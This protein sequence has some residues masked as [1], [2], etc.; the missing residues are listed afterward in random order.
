MLLTEGEQLGI[1]IGIAALIFAIIGI[2][3]A[4]FFSWFYYKKGKNETNQ[5]FKNQESQINLLGRKLSDLEPENAEMVK[6]EKTGNYDH[7]AKSRAI[8][9]EYT[10]VGGGSVTATVG[11]SASSPHSEKQNVE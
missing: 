10:P 3:L 11:R 5:K 7:L 2:G 9:P 8:A 1:N 6:D 4:G